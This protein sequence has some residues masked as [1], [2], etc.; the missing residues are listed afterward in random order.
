MGIRQLRNAFQGV[1]PTWGA[2]R[3]VREDLRPR[4]GAPVHRD[5]GIAPTIALH[6]PWDKV[7]DYAD[8]AAAAK[9]QGIELGTINANV[10]QDDDYKLG[11]LTNPDPRI[12]RKALDHLYECVDIMDET[13]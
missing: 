2:T 5:P 7:D 8:L 11:S 9:D 13:G 6:I 3:R 1:R 10:F 12:R 4:P